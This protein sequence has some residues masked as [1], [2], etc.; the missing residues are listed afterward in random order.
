MTRPGVTVGAQVGYNWQHGPFVWGFETDLS[1]LD[2]RRGPTGA[3]LASPAYPAPPVFTLN[4]NSSANFFASIRGRVGYAWDRSLF[5]L[6]GGVAAGGERG[7]AT[8]MLGAGG[9]DAIFHAPG[10]VSSRMKYVIGAGFEYAFADNWSARAEYL[11]L[12]QS[13]NTQVFDNGA[14]FIYGSRIR[15][16]NHLIRFGLNYHFGENNRTSGPNRIW[17]AASR[18]QPWR[19]QWSEFRRRPEFGQWRK[20]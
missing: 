13:L 2:G 12:N 16:E 4:S 7:P 17:T 5:Y 9:P 1:L 19:R 10:S 8:L 11:F 18:P 6:T 15:N 20:Q 3:Y 14:D